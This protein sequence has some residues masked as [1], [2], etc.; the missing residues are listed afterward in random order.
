M[1]P[2]ILH[3]ANLVAWNAVLHFTMSHGE[4]IGLV[5][6]R[7]AGPFLTIASFIILVLISVNLGCLW[8]INLPLKLFSV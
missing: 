3:Y 6:D 1:I 5:L 2:A 8:I 4:S 7:E